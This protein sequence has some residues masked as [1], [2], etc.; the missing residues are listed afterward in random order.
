[1]PDTYPNSV[2][3]HRMGVRGVLFL[4]LVLVIGVDLV[5]EDPAE[6]PDSPLKQAA[7][8]GDIDEADCSESKDVPLHPLN[9]AAC[10]GTV[11]SIGPVS[12]KCLLYW[13]SRAAS[14]AAFVPRLSIPRAPPIA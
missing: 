5:F 14:P 4:F 11:P 1:M 12:S 2:A 9:Q 3:T 6:S 7:L 8:L 10:L 13:V